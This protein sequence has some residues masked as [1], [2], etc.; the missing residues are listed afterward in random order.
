MLKRADVNDDKAVNTNDAY[1]LIQY[2]NKS[3][4][5]SGIES[6]TDNKTSQ[7]DSTSEPTVEADKTE[8]ES[9]EE[10]A[11]EK[12]AVLSGKSYSSAFLTGENQ[13]YYSVRI[14]NRWQ[15]A[16]SAN[17]YQIELKIKNNSEKTVYNTSADITFTSPVS[18]ESY[19]GCTVTEN[20]TGALTVKTNNEGS[21][22]SGGTFTCSFVV[23]S[24]QET[25]I[26]AVVK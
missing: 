18:V 5:Q 22:K 20:E 13:L 8:P 14:V 9:N 24:A 2:V 7:P 10:T 23:S 16:D 26:S 17:M 4:N 11:D 19:N 12:E 21:I 1:Y 3:G 6:V 15:S 25:D